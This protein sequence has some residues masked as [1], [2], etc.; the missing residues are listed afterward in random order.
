MRIFILGTGGILWSAA[1]QL[2]LSGHGSLAAVLTRNSSAA[3]PR[4][5]LDFQSLAREFD[6]PFLVSERLDN[7]ELSFIADAGADICLSL[8][9]S[10]IPPEV[11]ALFPHGLLTADFGD[12]VYQAGSSLDVWSLLQGKTELTLS[13]RHVSSAPGGPRSVAARAIMTLDEKA[14]IADIR[15]YAEA[16]L[17]GLFRGVMERLGENGEKD[18]AP[19]IA[20]AAHPRYHPLLR[21]D[22]R[23]D[24]SAPAEA[25][26][27]KVRAFT[28]PN[29]GAYTYARDSSGRVS[30][31]YVWR[32][33]PVNS[34]QTEFGS[35]GQVIACNGDTGEAI[36]L[37]GDGLLALQSVSENT[38]GEWFAPGGVWRPGGFHLGLRV[39]DE[40]FALLSRAQG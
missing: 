16:N 10:P 17:P 33:A 21:Q 32:A 6:A 22:G 34:R 5:E 15:N 9:W 3:S 4:T 18:F 30:L 31:V 11:P 20:G 37:T 36:V 28:R 19:V 7:Q 26:Y 29:T 39:E 23:I 12:P 14:T 25:I 38:G 35:P 27:A 40:L 2:H 1:R 8:G 24:W 13:V